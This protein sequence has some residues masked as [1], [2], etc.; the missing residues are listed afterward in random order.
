MYLAPEAL[1]SP[2]T[3]ERLVAAKPRLLA[4]DEAHCISEW[5]ES[6][7][8]AYLALGAMRAALDNPTT[9]ALT[10]TATPRTARDIVSRLALRDPVVVSG[11]FDR[12]NLRLA[13]RPIASEAERAATLL[14]LGANAPGPAIV[15]SD[16]RRGT[17][18]LAA[19][20]LRAGVAAAPFHAGLPTAER[21]ILQDRFQANRLRLIVATNAFGMG[22]DKPDVRLVVH[23][24]PPLTLE[25]YY[26]EAGRGGR[27][28]GI[29][30]CIVLLGP[31]DLAR[32]S[33]RIAATKVTRRLL[34]GVVEA[35]SPG[36]RPAVCGGRE[37]EV[38]AALAH[39]LSVAPRDVAAAIR[40]L[41]EDTLLA[42]TSGK[43]LLRLLATERRLL[44]DPHVPPG[45]AQAL[46][47]FVR[48]TPTHHASAPREVTFRDLTSLAP[49]RDVRA[50]LSRLE[51][52]QLA[53][54]QPLEPP[55]ALRSTPAAGDA[56]SARRAP[57]AAAVARPVE[58]PAGGAHGHLVALPP[59]G[60]ASI[61]RGFRT[62]GRVRCMRQLRIRRLT[63]IPHR[64]HRLAIRMAMLTRSDALA[65]RART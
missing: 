16:T 8:P 57:R 30:D 49:E 18:R 48:S 41:S 11:G 47:S 63:R 19:A 10:A 17:E 37:S 55:W 34:A 44:E 27:D 36:A 42:P 13:V 45:D 59:T 7:R 65:S 1:A 23:A 64:M 5:G 39:L 12:T 21:A 53:C 46:L 54:W 62:S 28:G 14:S 43:G 33:G 4:I 56:R 29:A 40:L 61:F 31:G 2:A 52:N 15:Y 58:T 9:I 60:P 50:W 38:F 6:F 20:Y 24:A 25:A 51:A 22:V 35:L 32:A 3:I 26:Q